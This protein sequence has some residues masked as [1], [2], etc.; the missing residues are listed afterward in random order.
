MFGS[1]LLA[2]GLL[3]AACLTALPDQAYSQTLQSC[4]S[5]QLRYV[6]TTCRGIARCYH[7]AYRKGLPV[8]QS[9][10]D[11]RDAE[12]QSRFALIESQGDCLTEPAGATVSSM[13]DSGID[14]QVA[15]IGG[16]GRCSGGKI[17]AIGR[18]CKQ[19]V[20]CYAR[21]T[22][23]SEPVD[24]FCL[25]K[26]SAKMEDV[27]ERL[28][29]KYGANC[30]TQNDAAARDA[31]NLQMTEDIYDYLRGTG[32]TTTTTSMS[33]STTTLM[34]EGCAEDGSFTACVAYR[35]N[36]ACQACVDM[37]G[38]IPASQCGGASQLGTNCSDA[39]QNQ[40]CAHAINTETACAATC[41][42]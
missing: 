38:G 41:C 19:L 29:L 18:S 15:A 6:G 35:D 36:G 7:K 27:F 30:A 12:L 39:F 16:A 17:G 25:D 23:G 37:V 20:S 9:C 5:Q 40:A 34:P 24:P 3:S 31:D 28:E 11:E 26:S 21:A 32:T 4:L 1:R 33:T 2:C 13:L 14:A 42:P 22:D 8:E 10:L